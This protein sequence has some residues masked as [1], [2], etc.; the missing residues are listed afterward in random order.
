TRRR[1]GQLKALRNLQLIDSRG[2]EKL[3][4]RGCTI[5]AEGLASALAHEIAGKK[6]LL[7]QNEDVV[8]IVDSTPDFIITVDSFGRVLFMNDASRQ[9]FGSQD[10]GPEADVRFTRFHRFDAVPALKQGFLEASLVGN[11]HGESV[12]INRANANVPVSVAI[13]AHQRSEADGILYTLLMRDVTIQK[14]LEERLR[15]AVD[16]ERTLREQ[17]EDASRVKDEFLQI[18]SHE[19]RTPMTPIMGWV[20]MIRN[21]VCSEADREKA[22]EI[23]SRNASS[24]LR[25][26]NDLLE[27]SRIVTGK[28]ALDVSRV[29]LDVIVTEAVEVVQL[30]ANAKSIEVVVDLS[31]GPVFLDADAARV[32]QVLW[33]LMANAVKFT[34]R[35]GRIVVRTQR[36]NSMVDVE[37][38]DN[39]IGIDSGFLPHVFDRFRQSDSSA[40][41]KHGG[42]GLGLAIAKS[43]V[44]LH[45]GEMRVSSEGLNK[46][47]SFTLQL[48][49]APLTPFHLE[50][51]SLRG[52]ASDSSARLDGLRLLVVDNEPDTLVTLEVALRALGADVVPLLS[53]LQVDSAL[54]EGHFDAFLS[55]V[56]MPELDGIELIRSQRARER[57]RGGHLPSVALTA[58]ASVRNSDECL[59]AGFDAHLAK[60]CDIQVLARAIQEVRRKNGRVTV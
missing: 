40:T 55:D 38:C 44:E 45:G 2:A 15:A 14:E 41:R 42:L 23:I 49:E 26:I 48:P 3:Q 60:P 28:I 18:L 13:V 16:T 22:I 9:F 32:K 24:Q 30:A 56:N 39:G 52:E 27:M 6:I 4:T 58:L 57:V 36:V 8:A 5:E 11:W 34:H 37:V 21:G 46:G 7:R 25:L 31:I 54:S 29:N 10:V 19:L 17:A 51:L 53:P 20:A 47:S 12:V 50:E 1:L 59:A 33:N 43:I 35:K